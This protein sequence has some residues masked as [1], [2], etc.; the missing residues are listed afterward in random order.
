M[1]TFIAVTDNTLFTVYG[2]LLV[3]A[4]EF[5][6]ILASVILN[7][8]ISEINF[9][10]ANI[11]ICK[12]KEYHIGKRWKKTILIL[13]GCIVNTVIFLILWLLFLWTKN[14]MFLYISIQSIGI[15]VLNM[16]PIESLDGGE[17]L[18]LIFERFFENTEFSKRICNFMSWLFL[19]VLLSTGIFTVIKFKCGFSVI[20]LIFYLIYQKY[21]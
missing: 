17:L 14:L 13:G 7:M 1:L 2:L 21:I 15:A 8:R 5:G 10:V 12:P 4:H 18:N 9:G 3:I 19:M 20:I 6:H 16:L 11:D